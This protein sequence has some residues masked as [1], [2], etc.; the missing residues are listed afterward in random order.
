[1]KTKKALKVLKQ[2]KEAYETDV[3]SSRDKE[4]EALDKVIKIMKK[5]V[6]EKEKDS[7]IPFEEEEYDR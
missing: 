2:I 4:I 3:I 7:G 5:R 6:K 1:M